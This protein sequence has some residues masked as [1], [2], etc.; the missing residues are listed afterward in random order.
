MA[1]SEA[2]PAGATAWYEVHV[3]RGVTMH[4]ADGTPLVM[5]IYRPMQ[6]GQPIAAGLPTLLERTPYDRAG[7]RLVLSAQYYARRGYA[8]VLQ[9]VRGRYDS[10]GTFHHNL[11]V[12]D[13]GLDGRDTHA[14]IVGQPWSNGRIGTFGGSFTAANQQAA[15]LRGAAGLQAQVLRDCGTNYYRRFFRWHGAFSLTGTLTFCTHQGENGRE[16]RANPAVRTALH[17][18]YR[19]LGEWIDRMPIQ[20]GES[21]LAQAPEYEAIF[22]KTMTEGDFTEYW[23]GPGVLIEGRWDEYP[24]DVAI[25]MVSGWYGNHVAGSF[26][27]FVELGKRLSKPIH[28][29]VGPWIHGP[30]MGEETGAGDIE[31]G[32]DALAQGPNLDTRVRWFDRWVRDVPN[33]VEQDA[34]LK[35]FVM[36]TGDGHK[37]E[38]GKLF[39]GGYWKTAWTWPLPETQFTTMYLQPAGGLETVP[40]A[41]DAAPSTYDYDPANPCPSIGGYAHDK[42]LPSVVLVGGQ[43][44]R[45][46]AS[47]RACRGD[48]RPLAE[49]DDVLV[50]QT[51][52]LAADTE[53]TGPL[54]VRLFVSTSAL[55]TDFAAK[56]IDVYPPSGDYPDG[57]ALLLSEGILRMRYRDDRL[58]GEPVTPGEVYEIALDLQPTGNVFKR[59]HRIRLDVTSSSFPEFDA[60]PNT[61]E[62]LGRHT[63]T[64][65]AHQTVFHDAAR[66]SRVMLP[67]IPGGR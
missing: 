41:A 3:E 64:V 40:P 49:R 34:P 35:L 28:L 18:M 30:G 66:P 14:W 44:Q 42:G 20:A 36:G 58:V 54:D 4:A 50:F 10:G 2:A 17:E 8:V 7:S 33:G 1:A 37:T 31:C 15:A 67:I 59:G 5:D 22:L 27:K 39:H 23:K 19:N 12:P 38:D 47:F 60:N 26:D 9:D 46:R 65:V 51:E 11:N 6:D 52:P 62:P 56:L 55:D 48:T 32:P 29:I 24:K 45:G 57:Y 63:H 16:A 53:V 61:G 13:E 21:P 25:L 43:D